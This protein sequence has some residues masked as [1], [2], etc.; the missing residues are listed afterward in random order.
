MD[1]V[2]VTDEEIRI[3]GSNLFWR[4][5]QR[6]G[7]PNLRPEFSLLFRSGAPD[8]IRTAYHRR[9][10]RGMINLMWFAAG[11]VAGGYFVYRGMRAAMV[12][13]LQKPPWTEDEKEERA[14]MLVEATRLSLQ[15]DDPDA[16]QRSKE[17]RQRL[18]DDDVGR[19]NSG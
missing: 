5:A 10:V 18:I 15:T 9:E 1:E 3:S 4:G 11:C 6:K 12:K 14:R 13:E 17:L 8:R 19:G 7:L 16:I 2:R